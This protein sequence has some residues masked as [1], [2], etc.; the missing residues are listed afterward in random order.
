MKILFIK[1]SESYSTQ[2][3]I[4]D[5]FNYKSNIEVIRLNFAE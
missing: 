5:I 3:E 4:I 2:K 1:T